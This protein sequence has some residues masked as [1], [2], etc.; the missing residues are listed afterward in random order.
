MKKYFL[1][2]IALISLLNTLYAQ[3]SGTVSYL[4]YNNRNIDLY[5]SGNLMPD[6]CFWDFGDG[7]S[8]T[9][10]G[11]TAV[12]MNY[13]Y[14]TSG[15]YTVTATMYGHNFPPAI[16]SCQYTAT[17]VVTV[18][19]NLPPATSCSL[20]ASVTYNI[21]GPYTYNF[22][23]GSNGQAISSP[24]VMKIF[25]TSVNPRQQVYYT[26]AENPDLTLSTSNNMSFTTN[27]QTAGTYE[28]WYY[29]KKYT[30]TGTGFCEDST[31]AS[32]EI[33]FAQNCQAGFTMFEDSTNSG[34]WFAY[35]TSTGDNLTYQWTFGDGTSSTQQY[36]FHTYAVPGHYDICL[37]IIGDS[38]V[39]DFCDTSSVHRMASGNM[40]SFNVLAPVGIKENVETVSAISVFPNPFENYMTVKFVST[41]ST[42]IVI[43]LYDAIGK[44]VL[45]KET[46]CSQGENKIELSTSELSRGVYTLNI[47]GSSNNFNK[48]IKLIK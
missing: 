18:V 37:R 47:K 29:I 35:N 41:E 17:K 11:T 13:S 45:Q 10:Y 3:C 24:C 23:G 43:S 36:P 16:T 44:L 31:F 8:S 6:S 27:F 7:N 9:S 28:I 32:F 46:K 20:T 40:S 2:S 22:I 12:S 48:T 26:A 1:I 38:C 14:S 25:K 5:T 34:S 30:G 42:S 33:A 21:T 4:K 39:S 15:T 19:D